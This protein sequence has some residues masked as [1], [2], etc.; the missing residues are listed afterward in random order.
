MTTDEAKPYAVPDHDSDSEKWI[1]L[2][3]TKSIYLR[4]IYTGVNE[5]NANEI[6]LTD[7]NFFNVTSK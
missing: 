5:S 4:V 7:I 2:D 1:D 6:A 3:G